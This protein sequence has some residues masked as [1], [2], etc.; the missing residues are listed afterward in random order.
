MESGKINDW[1]LFEVGDAGRVNNEAIE[2][3]INR[4]DTYYKSKHFCW[5]AMAVFCVSADSGNVYTFTNQP[6]RVERN[7]KVKIAHKAISILHQVI[8]TVLVAIVPVSHPIA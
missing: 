6:V 1:V 8:Q 3:S 4:N 7:L 2:I 5:R